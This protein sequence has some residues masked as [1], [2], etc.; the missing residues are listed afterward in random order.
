MTTQRLVLAALLV[1]VGTW[2]PV[3][4]AQT[5][6]VDVELGYQ[7]VDV[8]GNQDMYRT[9]LNQDDGV[10][11][12]DLDVAVIDTDGSI[13]LFDRLRVSAAGFGGNPAGHFRLT[14]DLDGLYSLTIDYRQF[15]LFSALPGFANPLAGAG[16]TPGLHTWDR[17]RNVLD[18]EIELLPGHAITPII[19]YS[20][21]RLDGPRRTTWHEG[22]DEFQL[23]SDLEETEEEF[24]VGAAFRFANMRGAVM[25]GWRSFESRDTATLAP[26][27]GDGVNGNPVLGQDVTA[28]TINRS[29][30]TDADTPVTSLYLSGAPADGVRFT[31]SY[32]RADADSKSSAEDLLSGSLVS[33]RIAR[34]FDSLEESVSSRTESP[35]WRGALRADFD[36]S[37]K[38]GFEL[39][40][41][42]HHR[43]LEGWALVSDLYLGT[44]NFSGADP[45]DIA[46][47]VEAHNSY[48]RDVDVL[49]ARFDVHDLGPFHLWAGWALEDT[50]VDVNQ[51]AAEIVVPG[52]Q[53]GRYDRQVQSWDFGAG[54]DA[55]ALK[56]LFDVANDTADD[57]VVRTDFVDRQRL[58]ARFDWAPCDH[59]SALATVERITA[60]NNGA[61]IALDATTDHWSLDVDVRP[62]ETFTI[63]A[64]WDRYQTDSSLLMRIPQSFDV[65]PSLHSEDGE[66][67]EG[68]LEWRI[69]EPL[70]VRAGYSTLD[71][72]GSLPFTL[73]R[74]FGRIGYDFT[75]EWGAALEYEA[76]KYSERD[77]A[78]ADFDAER[79]AVFVRWHHGS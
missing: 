34:F 13:G 67:L 33:F 8:D 53:E 76:N 77:F 72:T 31:A 5:T 73:D 38:V 60:E 27:A 25:Q 39:G 26:G 18:L 37:S 15:E 7:I 54:I 43:E 28:D 45:R 79:I 30:R 65:V 47:L 29:I 62:V 63:R 3:A 78:L 36:L 2:T 41:Q 51:A 74:T 44:L 9:Q 22:E 48:D 55:G 23:S 66:V 32:V 69:T 11:L 61:G 64:A 20:Y 10:V 58:R 14:S 68:S 17:D 71:N 35:S 1:A 42:R 16:I 6:S 24:R 50:T 21:N 57:I 12:G 19:G 75:D 56:M 59:F 46:T 52:G 40:Y 49:D 4:V 70:F